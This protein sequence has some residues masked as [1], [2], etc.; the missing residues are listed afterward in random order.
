MMLFAIKLKLGFIQSD[1]SHKVTILN[2]IRYVQTIKLIYGKQKQLEIAKIRKTINI[3]D[4]KNLFISFIIT[5]LLNVF[6][7]KWI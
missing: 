6:L 7:R 2:F 3:T 1:S 4:Y 5:V